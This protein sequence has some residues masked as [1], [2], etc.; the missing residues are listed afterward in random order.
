[1]KYGTWTLG[2]IE[3]LLNKLG[4]ENAKRLLREEVSVQ[5]VS[6][7]TYPITMNYAQSLA[8][9]IA[10]GKYNNVNENITAKNFPITGVGTVNLE[11]VLFQPNFQPNRDIESDDVV[12][13]MDQMG[14][15]PAT[16]PELCAYGATYPEP[17]REF[18]I[19]GLDSSWVRPSGDR[20]VP[21][22]AGWL[23]ERYMD[24]VGRDAKWH[25][26]HRFAAVRM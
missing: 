16:L 22:L 26:D 7:A 14:L 6:R 17:Q 11:I 24:L 5:F 20:V 3:A 19:V 8:D 4:E 9:M 18:L 25:A 23:D 2:Q 15:R 21:Y 10:A 13:E 1:M 12:K